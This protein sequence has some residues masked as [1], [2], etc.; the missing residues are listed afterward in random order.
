MIL[1]DECFEQCVC[2]FYCQ[3]VQEFDLVIVG[4]LCVVWCDVLQ[5][6][7]FVCCVV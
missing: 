5:L 6:M 2:V 7:L 4:C 1:F 3:V